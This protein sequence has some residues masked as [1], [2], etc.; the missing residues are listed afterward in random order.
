M[1]S[2]MWIREFYASDMSYS[3]VK[4]TEVNLSRIQK[5]L[6]NLIVAVEGESW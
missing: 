6:N 1:K 3:D 4:G 2:N 5:L